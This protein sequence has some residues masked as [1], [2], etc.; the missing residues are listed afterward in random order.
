MG[1]DSCPEVAWT[2]FFR[3]VTKEQEEMWPTA[4]RYLER[5]GLG[6]RAKRVGTGCSDAVTH[7]RDK[8]VRVWHASTYVMVDWEPGAR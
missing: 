7:A 6:F 8:P 4:V 2:A 5:D 1:G 3:E